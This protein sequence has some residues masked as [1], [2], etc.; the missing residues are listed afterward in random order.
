MPGDLGACRQ[1]RLEAIGIAGRAGNRSAIPRNGA[2]VQA[3]RAAG[4]RV[5]V[6]ASGPRAVKAAASPRLD[7][8]ADDVRP[9]SEDAPGPAS[10]VSG[11]NIKTA[12]KMW[13]NFIEPA[14]FESH[15]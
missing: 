15:V 5:L 1:Q 3:A 7:F 11:P 12:H 8:G 6:L 9:S 4:G 2:R 13:D 14:L 10:N